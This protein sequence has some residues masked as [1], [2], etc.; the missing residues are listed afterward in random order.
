MAK[1]IDTLALAAALACAWVI[2]SHLVRSARKGRPWIL[3]GRGLTVP[4]WGCACAACLRNGSGGERRV[5]RG[6]HGTRGRRRR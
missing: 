3:E 5:G 4:L 2:V 6:R 1:L